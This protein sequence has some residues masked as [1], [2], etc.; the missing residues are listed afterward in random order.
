MGSQ[1]V[2]IGVV[3]VVFLWSVTL[4]SSVSDVECSGVKAL[5]SACYYFITY[6]FPDPSPGS[7]CCN[8]MISI[9]MVCDNTVE[10]RRFTCRCLMSLFSTY[11]P[12]GYALATLPDFCQVS[13]G[14]IVDP[15]TD[16]NL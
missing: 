5:L 4:V 3:L 2:V 12:N 11:T 10:N 14:F 9:K 7:P 15:N 8:S 16:C 13:L 1:T 6:G